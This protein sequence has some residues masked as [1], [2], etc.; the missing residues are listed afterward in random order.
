MSHRTAGKLFSKGCGLFGALGHGNL[1][2]QSSFAPLDIQG[3]RTRAV[4]VGWGHSVA[5][6]DEDRLLVFGRPYEFSTLL[7]MHFIYRI[8]HSLAR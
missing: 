3:C 8:S 1:L 2:D 6:T 5:I 7:R 4:A